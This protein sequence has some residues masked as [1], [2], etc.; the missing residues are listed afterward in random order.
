[1]SKQREYYKRKMEKIKS[2]P[3]LYAAYKASEAMKARKKRE[4]LRRDPV[5]YEAAKEK[6]RKAV[7]AYRQK[8]PDKYHG[9]RREAVARWREENPELYRAQHLQ[10]TY[11]ISLDEYQR[12]LEV[13]NGHCATCPSD[14]PGGRGTWHVDHCHSTGKIRGLLC[15][16]CNTAL[17]L[18]KDN[19][20]TLRN[21]A[22][23]LEKQ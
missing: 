13:Q 14:T 7:K 11:G 4:Q 22:S 1:M 9:T 2:D 12:M 10:R 18:V 23:Y 8:N 15:R 6:H 5:K 16:A 19:P 21:L 20:E 17:G 3:L